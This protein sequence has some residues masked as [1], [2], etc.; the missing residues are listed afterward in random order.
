MRRC[1]HYRQIRTAE[2][3]TYLHTRQNQAEAWLHCYS[4]SYS[5]STE[6]EEEEE[7]EEAEE[8]FLTVVSINFC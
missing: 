1:W 7:F 2:G 4:L 3:F 8:S 6:D 5:A